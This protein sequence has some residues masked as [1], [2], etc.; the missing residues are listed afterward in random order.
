MEFGTELVL[1]NYEYLDKI[2]ELL[3]GIY[4]LNTYICGFGLFIVVVILLRYSYK[5]LNI[6]F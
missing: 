5:F 6:F 3:Q 1:E 2:L 4:E